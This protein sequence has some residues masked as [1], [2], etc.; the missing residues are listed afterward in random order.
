[1]TALPS[2]Y[3]SLVVPAIAAL[4]ALA[5]LLG[6]GTW[7]LS[8][9]AWK[10]ELVAQVAA[11]THAAPVALPSPAAW[12]A[13]TAERDEYRRVSVSGTFR[14]TGETYLYHVAGDS[15]RAADPAKV[16]GQGFLVFTPFVL[17]DG[18][19]VLVNRGFVPND[20]RDPATRASGQIEGPVTITG[21]IRFPEARSMLAAPDDAARRLFYTRDIGPMASAAGLGTNVVAPFSIDADPVALPGGLPQ[22]GETRLDFPNRHFEYALT[23]F[24]LALT[25]IGVFVA[26]VI[27]KLRAAA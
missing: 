7:Q 23:W 10:N 11:R 18:A 14:N 27:Q 9:L 24:G 20:R 6:L 12:S 26:F 22:G 13:M 15:R 1:M 3:R 2:P 17:A 5:V 21:L 19:T 8:R 4:S 16:Q 25:L